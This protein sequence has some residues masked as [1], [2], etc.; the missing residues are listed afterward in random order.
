M[1]ARVA[2]WAR[3]RHRAER[4][5]PVSQ[6]RSWQEVE[7]PR[8]KTSL[9][10]SVGR[11]IR[12]RTPRRRNPLAQLRCS[13]TF[14]VSEFSPPHSPRSCRDKFHERSSPK[15]FA[16]SR[17][18]SQPEPPPPIMPNHSSSATRR[19]GRRKGKRNKPEMR[20]PSGANWS[21]IDRK[22]GRTSTDSWPQSGRRAHIGNQASDV[23]TATGAEYARDILAIEMRRAVRGF[24]R[25]MPG[26]PA[27]SGHYP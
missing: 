11:W 20:T 7:P 6:Y 15:H 19:P 17:P 23:S 5:A 18:L 21:N 3:T 24:R 10:T 4:A 2:S 9:P 1:I 22:M 14:D 25:E 13:W 8:P 27:N 26:S 12:L 16:G